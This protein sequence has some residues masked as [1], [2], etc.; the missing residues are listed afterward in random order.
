MAKL[1]QQIDHLAQV[2]AM[3]QKNIGALAEQ[4][5]N[6]RQVID[7]SFALSYFRSR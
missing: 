4:L 6:S 5:N 7:T 3:S 1:T 2:V